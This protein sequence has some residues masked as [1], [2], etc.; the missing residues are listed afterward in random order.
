M[1]EAR[2]SIF[3]SEIEAQI[4]LIEEIYRKIEERKKGIEKSKSKLESL[5]YQLH[6]LYCAFED[7]FKI[8]ADFFD[9]TVEEKGRYHA[10]LLRRMSIFI[11][12]I[13]PALLSDEAYRLL[14]N[15]RAFRH[16][17]RH[18]YSYEIEL[19]KIKIVLDDA[20]RLKGIYPDLV[21]DFLERTREK[22]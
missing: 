21:K 11:R 20:L 14:D 18:A 22:K 6:N 5:A 1:D 16:F 7:S 15:L 3:E 17:F 4:S 13:R 8:V 9:N 19:R 2:F 12:G 10:E